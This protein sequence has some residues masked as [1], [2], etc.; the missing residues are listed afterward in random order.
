MGVGQWEGG[1]VKW[2]VLQC[3]VPTI[4][5]SSGRAG[6]MG[7]GPMAGW[8]T[9]MLTGAGAG[10]REGVAAK[11]REG[12]GGGWMNGWSDRWRIAIAVATCS[13]SFLR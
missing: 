13:I 7:D 1:T 3:S 4:F 6:P 5:D 10:G 12:N 11:T 2:M 9:R 8:K